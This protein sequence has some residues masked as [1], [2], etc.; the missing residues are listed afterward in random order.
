MR[1]V[2]GELRGRK[3]RTP[4][5]ERARP[6]T[7]RVREAVFNAL[8]SLGGVEGMAVLDLF[9]GTGALGIEAISRGASTATFVEQDRRMAEVLRANLSD[10]HLEGRATVHVG[11]AVRWLAD[12][13][14]DERFALALLDPP[15]AFDGWADLLEAL[16]APL[17]VIESDRMPDLPPTWGVVRQ[18]R[19][20]GT[21][22]A[23]VERASSKHV[24][25]T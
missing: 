2:A 25:D 16:P 15:Y 5:D 8:G 11:E 20:G 22:V 3:L 23:I 19:Y 1:V 12:R 17:A 4:P 18:K 6:T 7:D 13:P 9:A 24:G 21:I 14:A 10:L